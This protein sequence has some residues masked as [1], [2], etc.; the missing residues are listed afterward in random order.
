MLS[1]ELPDGR[2]PRLSWFCGSAEQCVPQSARARNRGAVEAVVAQGLRDRVEGV[3]GA[4]A[5]ACRAVQVV[6][7]IQGVTDLSWQVLAEDC[8]CVRHTIRAQLH[9]H[10]P[11]SIRPG[12]HQRAYRVPF[13]SRSRF[14][15]LGP[16]RNCL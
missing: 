12:H 16:A 4:L 7:P 8:S 5:E 13:R 1:N 14:R 15:D 6:F 11:Y 2:Y 10:D 9:G 3:F